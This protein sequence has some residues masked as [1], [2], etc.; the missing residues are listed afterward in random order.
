MNVY[1]KTTDRCSSSNYASI[2]SNILHRYGWQ[3][4]I[5]LVFWGDNKALTER[6]YADC[7]ISLKWSN[8]LIEQSVVLT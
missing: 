3:S 6:K 8:T 2:L 4:G 7:T 5:T 1:N